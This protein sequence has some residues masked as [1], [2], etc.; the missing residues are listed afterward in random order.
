[1][2]KWRAKSWRANVL[3]LVVT[4]LLSVSGSAV[5]ETPDVGA[6]APDFTLSTPEGQP[7]R[8]SEQFAKGKVVLIVLRGY[9]GYQCPYC[10]RQAHDFQTN[11]TRFAES[12]AQVV[13]VYPGPPANLGN[14]A[15]EFQAKQG[16]L[17]ANFHL[18][19][20]P[21]Y[22]FTNQYGLRWDAPDET[23]Y[24]STFVIDRTGVIRYRKISNE[25]GGRTTAEDVLAALSKE[26]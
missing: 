14:H 23:A 6:K 26:K 18:V 12:G 16:E 4:V 5:A 17:P 21:D 7:V 2:K 1:M 8:L 9:P 13:L 22:K 11:A 15:K 3:F 10:Q 20:D 25:H 24:P 19:I